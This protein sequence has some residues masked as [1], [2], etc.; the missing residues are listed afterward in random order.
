LASSRGRLQER[1]DDVSQFA[2]LPRGSAAPHGV[3]EMIKEFIIEGR[4]RAS[5][6]L[7]SEKSLAATLGVS[8]PTLREAIRGLMALNI[9]ESRH[10][11]GTYITTL[12]PFLLA[13]PLDFLL[14]LD[15]QGA[16]ASLQDA[17]FV[18]ETGIAGLAAAH[19]SGT[20]LDE[21]STIVSEY[22]VA[23][24]DVDRCIDLDQQFHEVI[25]EGCGNEILRTMLSTVAALTRESRRMTAQERAVRV[26][27]GRDHRAITL[28][29][30]ARS[31][32]RAREAMGR[33]IEHVYS[34]SGLGRSRDG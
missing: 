14:R 1:D 16:L 4:L 31:V 8:R 2:V 9:V 19:M 6:Q 25:A 33:H 17:R 10:G 21:L 12:D 13:A 15:N 32:A 26:R 18:L 34:T 24:D 3:I 27:S 23:I 5:Q 11:S 22:D 7:P 29:I 30:R 28:A 20:Q